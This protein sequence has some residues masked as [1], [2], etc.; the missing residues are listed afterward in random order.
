MTTG[1]WTPREEAI[2]AAAVDLRRQVHDMADKFGG[3]YVSVTLSFEDDTQDG[4]LVN[5]S[6]SVGSA[7]DDDEQ[8]DDA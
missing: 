4:E 8:G 5:L 3:A 1:D 6:Y 7:G 2:A